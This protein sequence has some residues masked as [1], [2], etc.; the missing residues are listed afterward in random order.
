[1]RDAINAANAGADAT[2][3]TATIVSISATEQVLILSADA[4]G[5]DAG[6]SAADSSGTVLQSLG[7]LDGSGALKNELQAAQNAELLVDG[8]STVIER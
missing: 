2:G 3:V 4:T 5:T 8:L 6:I 1:L 7:L